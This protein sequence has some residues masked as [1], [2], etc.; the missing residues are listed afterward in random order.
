[1]G[2]GFVFLVFLGGGYF[3]GGRSVV[4]I[5]QEGFVWGNCV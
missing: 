3:F 5:L 1:M 2:G 4:L